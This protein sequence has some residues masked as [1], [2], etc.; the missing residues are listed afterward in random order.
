MLNYQMADY[1][2]DSSVMLVA[3]LLTDPAYQ[4]NAIRIEELIHHILSTCRGNKIPTSAAIRHWLNHLE[5]VSRVRLREDPTEDIFVSRIA[6]PWGDFLLYDG[7]WESNCFYLDMVLSVIATF[8]NHF[9]TETLYKPI[10]ALLAVSDQIARRNGR[11]PNK[12][13]ANRPWVTLDVPSKDK[14]E[15]RASSLAFLP[16]DLR[17]M[18][19]SIDSLQP[20]IIDDKILD[21]VKEDTSGNS[22]LVKSPLL[23]VGDKILVALPTAIGWAIRFFVFRWLREKD[24]EQKFHERLVLH[25]YRL[26]RE[27]PGLQKFVP[28]RPVFVIDMPRIHDAYFYEFATSFDQNKVIH[29]VV[30]IDSLVGLAERGI[31]SLPEQFENQQKEISERITRCSAKALSDPRVKEGFTIIVS[32]GYGRAGM[33]FG[34]EEHIERWNVAMISLCDLQTLCWTSTADETT[35]FALTK[36]ERHIQQLGILFQNINGPLNLYGWWKQRKGEIVPRMVD[37][38]GTNKIVDI[39]TGCIARIRRDAFATVD[40]R[41]AL[42]VDGRYRRLRRKEINSYFSSV[43]TSALYLDFDNF[44]FNPFSACALVNS[45]PWWVGVTGHEQYGDGQFVYKVFDAFLYWIEHVAKYAARVFGPLAK[46]DPIY[47]EL[48]FSLI[49]P[50]ETLPHS[51][52]AD[53]D[54]ISTYSI[55]STKNTIRVHLHQPFVDCIHSTS[56]F[57]EAA[58]VAVALEAFFK[59]VG[60]YDTEHVNEALRK[61]IPNKFSRQIHGFQA[62]NFR[63]NMREFF[64]R[65]YQLINEFDAQLYKVGLGHFETSGRKN[66]T[67]KAACTEFLNRLVA[68]R[69]GMLKKELKRYS[70]EGLIVSLF[71]N[72]EALDAERTVWERTA[73]AQ[74]NLH[75]DPE[76]IFKAR[77]EHFAGITTADISSRILIE[78]ALCESP[79]SGDEKYLAD[80]DFSPLLALANTIFLLGGLSDGMTK[81]VVKAEIEVAPSGDVLFYQD[82]FDNILNPVVGMYE[83]DRTVQNAKDYERNFAFAEKAERVLA[84]DFYTPDLLYAFEQEFGITIDDALDFLELLC[85]IGYEKEQ[86]ILSL[87]RSDLLTYA[88]NKPLNIETLE[89]V[90][91]TFSLTSRDAWEKPSPGYERRDINPWLFRRRLSIMTKPVVKIDDGDDPRYVIA[92]GF[93]SDALAY[94]FELY[95][96]CGMEENR[97]R[98]KAMKKWV[99]DE[100]KR[101]GSEFTKKVADVLKG[102]GFETR[103]EVLLSS[104]FSSKETKKDYGDV[105]VVAWR[106]G[107]AEIHLIEC[108][109]LLF[110]KTISELAEQVQEYRGIVK[111]DGSSDNLKKHIDR[112][113]LISSNMQRFLKYLQISETMLPISHLIFSRPVPVLFSPDLNA[114]VK[115]HHLGAIVESNHFG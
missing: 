112:V 48:D 89:K 86:G 61:I 111:P 101:R 68:H 40:Q 78:M 45:K 104:I 28:P 114:T 36:A 2:R 29:F 15:Q 11:R 67:G 84:R 60:R 46:T 85:A 54:Q 80:L 64:D 81:E 107:S 47:Y 87:K 10:K 103:T 71:S 43:Y 70:R 16:E 32:N 76:D 27:L 14:V 26:L 102:F 13:G 75:V 38:D 100:R 55:D 56:N 34:P 52:E 42:F 57:S 31:D 21:Q 12:L 92:P 37:V 97:C 9:G 7:V 109:N 105:D 74:L 99:G 24:L 73:R 110:A 90:L 77:K 82:F 4:A 51:V 91:E 35:L 79:L 98:S 20:F 108:K 6:T 88:R 63:E 17:W 69:Y 58:L 62:K 23:R 66:F 22:F 41:S 53:I 44:Y 93:V 65:R 59:L 72:I 3:G 50:A 115:I 96:T 83:T 1:D 113:D 39:P 94:T 25:S 49:H 19:M 106:P 95:K 18:G 33:I 8:P 30:R 5:L